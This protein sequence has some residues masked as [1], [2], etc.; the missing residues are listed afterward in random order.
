[1]LRAIELTG[2]KSFADKTRFEFPKGITVIVGPNG[3]GKSNVVDAIKWVLGEQSPKSLR[4]KEMADVIFNGSGSRRPLNAAD[5]TL[6]LDNAQSLLAVETSE[7][8]ITRRV[9]RSGE[10][11]YLINRQPSR[12]R[13]IRDLF[14]GT[15]VAT[16]AYSVIEQGK[17]DVLLQSS[18]KDRRLIFEEAA[19]ISRFKAKKLEATRRLERVDQ[20]LLRLGDI[21]E[22]VESRLRSVRLQ[23]SKARRYREYSTRLKEL[24]TDLALVDWRRLTEA[25]AAADAEMSDLA[26][27]GENCRAE[28]QRL[29]AES[30]GVET[31][32]VEL[33]EAIR[34]GE[35]RMAEVREKIAA[36]ESLIEGQRARAQELDEQTARLRRQQSAL[37]ARAG[38]ANE[39][40]AEVQRAVAMLVE[41]SDRL[42][43]KLAED[44]AAQAR[45]AVELERLRAAS[46]RSRAVYAERTREAAVIDRELSALEAQ[47]LAAADALSRAAVRIES[48]AQQMAAAA[49]ELDIARGDHERSAAEIARLSSAHE[50][51]QAELADRRQEHAE[52]QAALADLR[53]RRTAAQER[54]TLLAELEEKLEGL[55]TGVKQALSEARTRGDSI[56]R[57]VR[58]LVADVIDVNVDMAPLVDVALGEVAGHL[59]VGDDRKLFD[60]LAEGRAALA[61]RVALIRYDLKRPPS[62]SRPADYSSQPGVVGR[63]DQFVR[64]SD[65]Y[66]ALVERL[67]GHTW[68]VESLHVALSL[69]KNAGHQE[70]FVT[71]AGELV[72]ADGSIVVGPRHAATGLVSRR[73]E[74]RSL[75]DQLAAYAREIEASERRTSELSASVARCETQVNS[76]ASELR[77]VQQLGA[78]HGARRQAA[79]QRGA[80]FAEQ[81]A[82]A[83]AERD[84]AAERGER[85]TLRAAELQTTRAAL[86]DAIAAAEAEIAAERAR[87]D[88]LDNQR[89][90]MLGQTSAARVELAKAE[91]QLEH[92]REQLRQF[93]MHREERRRATD[94]CREQLAQCAERQLESQR[95]ILRAESDVAALYLDKE[96]VAAEVRRRVDL[97]EG[98]RAAKNEFASRVQK[99]RARVRVIDDTSHERQLAAG[100]VRHERSVLA[101]RLREDYD[102]DLAELAARPPTIRLAPRP[103]SE[104]SDD[105]ANADKEAAALEDESAEQPFDRNAAEAEIAD[106]RRKV[107]AIG[108]VNLDALAE[109]DELE[110]RHAALAAQHNDLATAKSSL[111]QI[112]DKINADSRRLFGDT[113][114]TVRGHFQQLFRKLFGGGQADIVLEEGIDILDAGIEIVA[115]P[116]GKEPRNISLLSGGEKTLT[117]VALLLAV[118]RNRPSPFCVLDEVDA[119]LDEANIERFV[120]VLREFLTITQFIVVTH[121]K[122]TMTA[123]STLYGVTMQESGISKRVSVRFEDVSETGE[124]SQAAIARSASEPV[125]NV[126]ESYPPAAETVITAEGESLGDAVAEKTADDETQAA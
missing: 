28:M 2:F 23:A 111:E 35:A 44:D 92:H 26:Q 54:A 65:E 61:G 83:T 71:L 72:T 123:A 43:A 38:D 108:G 60:A 8:K 7:V 81:F 47:R 104:I 49:A 45:L 95:A 110:T 14:A 21:V 119:A 57:D 62:W 19:G 31:E 70:R 51:A 4:G 32:I 100:E 56:F 74:L 116:P 107:N 37:A 12:L 124:I 36:A 55:S 40:I 64:T 1:M 5:V 33:D 20:N 63:A 29:E 80:Q 25:L 76:L 84:A 15:G 58:G 6:T 109:L 98:R 115:R 10:S 52:Q 99:L 126:D 102:L 82:A 42:R 16:E 78:E 112:I 79:E 87:E 41:Q 13:D 97:R 39:Q 27:D 73:S 67:L 22:E 101:D 66:A 118:F 18:P 30:L 53:I 86:T 91:Q 120:G 69:A 3:S 34:G 105:A 94:E 77:G 88:S 125:D 93:E 24:R 113:L 75:R 48:L 114:E 68:I 89:V 9:Y 46:E 106:L 121:S 85:A 17:V 90:A 96:A 103:V 117:C 122:K 59:V 50:S 11:E